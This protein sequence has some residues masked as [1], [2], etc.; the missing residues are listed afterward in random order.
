MLKCVAAC[1][2]RFLVG[3]VGA[4]TKDVQCVAVCCSVLQ[5]VAAEFWWGRQVGA[6]TKEV[7]TLN[8]T[9]ASL[10]NVCERERERERKRPSQKERRPYTRSCDP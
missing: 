9:N 10:G 7:A 1:C 5:C 6:L 2:S 3:Q 4:L 8:A